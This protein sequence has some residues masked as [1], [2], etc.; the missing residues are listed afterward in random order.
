MFHKC[1]DFDL[2]V[3]SVCGT[4]I[5]IEKFDIQKLI[6]YLTDLDKKNYQSYQKTALYTYKWSNRGLE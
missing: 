3:I 5:L 1:G 4:E 2:P 6:V